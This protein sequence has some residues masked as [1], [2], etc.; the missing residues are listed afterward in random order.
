MSTGIWKARLDSTLSGMERDLDEM[1]RQARLFLERLDS[2]ERIVLLGLMLI[3]V[4]FFLLHHFKGSDESQ[5]QVGQFV[6][7]LFA[8]VTVAAVAGWT[9]ADYTA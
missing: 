8:M 1:A 9:V 7:V 5:N 4:L 3:G 6:G 2:T